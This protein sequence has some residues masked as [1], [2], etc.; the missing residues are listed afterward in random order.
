MVNTAASIQATP[1]PSPAPAATDQLDCARLRPAAA[2][3]LLDRAE[4]AVWQELWTIGVFS[5]FLNLLALVS[6]LYM[7]QVFDRVLSSGSRETLVLLTLV[8]VGALAVF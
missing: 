7:M 2:A 6:S 3:V 8:A 1:K 4:A 5:L